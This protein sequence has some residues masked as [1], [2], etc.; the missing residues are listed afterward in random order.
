MVYNTTS[1]DVISA[2]PSLP[3]TN[4]W[5]AHG[6]LKVVGNWTALTKDEQDNM[7]DNLVVTPDKVGLNSLEVKEFAVGR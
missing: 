6:E 1:S 2:A 5:F 7:V 3:A 4:L